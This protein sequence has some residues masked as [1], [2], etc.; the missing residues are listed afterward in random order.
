MNAVEDVN[1]PPNSTS[2]S[3]SSPQ[4][5]TFGDS[6]AGLVLNNPRAGTTP[7]T[8]KAPENLEKGQIIVTCKSAN[9]TKTQ[10]Y[11]QS[12]NPHVPLSVRQSPENQIKSPVNSVSVS[13]IGSTDNAAVQA[14]YV[15]FTTA[16]GE[17]D[18]NGKKINI[19]AG[20]LSSS[21]KQ[22]LIRAALKDQNIKPTECHE[23]ANIKKLKEFFEENTEGLE[24]NEIFGKDFSNLKDF[25]R[26]IFS[27][28]SVAKTERPDTAKAKLA[29]ASGGAEA[30]RGRALEINSKCLDHT[31]RGP[32][33][34]NTERNNPQP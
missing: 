34:E 22:G 3:T 28:D 16:L 10:T 23:D 2:S 8:P 25:T 9:E 27:K 4:V 30:A 32:S 33:H 1:D 13:W 24:N 7:P 26:T 29:A 21:F 6:K 19:Q 14:G 15:G 18:R 20:V 17:L 11:H 5:V 12:Q 31:Q